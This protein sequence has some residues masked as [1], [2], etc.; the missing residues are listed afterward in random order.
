MPVSGLCCLITMA[1][2]LRDISGFRA[3]MRI[4]VVK[5][6]SLGDVVHTLPAISDAATRVKNIEIDW[7]VEENF[8]SIPQ[9]HGSVSNVITAA[10]RRWRRQPGRFIPELE[11]LRKRLR[12]TAYDLIIDAQGLFKSALLASL[13]RGQRAGY[14]KLSIRE[15]NASYFY[16]R[17]YSVDPTLHAVLRTRRLFASA[18]G[19]DTDET[20]FY[21]LDR[22]QFS[23][24]EKTDPYL[25]FLHG[26][27]WES[28][29]WPLQCWQRLADI[30]DKKGLK[31]KLLW[32][33]E[34]EFVRAAA[35]ARDRQN[36]DVCAKMNLD[37]I[38]ALISG[39]QAVVAADTGLGHL[40]AALSVPC[41]SLY[42]ATDSSRT[43]TIGVSQKHLQ[44]EFE[45]SPCLSRQCVYQGP[46][47]ITPACFEQFSAQV[48][49]NNI[50]KL[51]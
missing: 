21:G 17:K 5:L 50:E 36:V 22:G 1:P 10:S 3:S 14:D 25:V 49:W 39:A 42:G 46:S 18:L 35:I 4:L 51:I 47:K 2:H 23:T 24:V 12:A 13:A 38:A 26:T 27:T 8:K 45:C 9:W 48:V 43:G 32:G 30:S 28:K 40:A 11:I 20:I 15:S 29:Q 31:I 37:E 19:Y 34:E 7:L 6:T 33:N 41:V 44:A 16:H